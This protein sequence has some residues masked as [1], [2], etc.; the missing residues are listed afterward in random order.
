MQPPWAAHHIGMV[1]GLLIIAAIAIREKMMPLP[2][3]AMAA[4]PLGRPVA[5][6]IMGSR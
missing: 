3:S 4:I 2:R 1:A 6:V 5:F